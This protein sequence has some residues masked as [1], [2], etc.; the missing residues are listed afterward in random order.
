MIKI[1]LVASQEVPHPSGCPVIAMGAFGVSC[2]E[3][4]CKRSLNVGTV[5]FPSTVVERKVIRTLHSFVNDS[6][7]SWMGGLK[8][9]CLGA[10]IP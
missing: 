9:R 10:S 3:L 6:V 4:Q 8:C 7:A 1:T 5:G 2:N